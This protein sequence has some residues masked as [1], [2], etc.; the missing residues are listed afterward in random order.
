MAIKYVTSINLNKNELQNATIQNLAAA[1]GAP[2]KG[3]VYFDTA[4]DHAYVYNGSGWEQASGA[5]GTGSVTSVGLALPA[6]LAV[7]GSP[8]TTAGTLS[9]AWAVEP[10]NAVHAGPVAGAAAAPSW[11]A[12][13]AADLPTLDALRAPVAPLALGAQRLTGLADPAGPQDAATKAYVDAAI[14]GLSQK[15]EAAVATNAALNP[16][17]YTNGNAGVGAAITFQAVGAQVVDGYA[18]APGDVVLVKNEPTAA[19]NGLYA[20]TQA[21]DAGHACILT[22]VAGMDTAA[23]FQGAFIPVG[24]SGAANA[25]S[26]WLCTNATAPVVGTTAITFVQ[27]NKGTDL[28]AGAGIAIAGNTVSVAATYA[29]GPSIA[30]LG[31]IAAGTWQAT[32]VG[33]AYGGTGATS[34]PGARANLAVPGKY[35]QTIGNAS[36]TSFTITQA[37]HGLAGDSALIVQ[38]LDDSTGNVVFCDASVNKANGSVTLSFAT[39]PAANQY[40]VVLMG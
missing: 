15:P 24:P 26:L 13:V 23:E 2:V 20:V 21:G 6:D 9:A 38:V 25:N 34:A 4:Q 8:V 11:R 14:Q 29:G 12:L 7:A 10:A 40:R 36:A 37:A 31:T 27:L 35:Q 17:L 39:P 16:Y 28:A 19:N 3:Q 30:T 1:P 22:R 5:S 32:P 33:L 18:L